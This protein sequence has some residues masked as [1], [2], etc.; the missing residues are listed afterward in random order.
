[1]SLVLDASAALAWI[2]ERAD[3]R[4]R[5]LADRLL[6]TLTEQQALVPVLWHTE[7][8]NAVLVAE[9]RGVIREAQSI[10]YLH[11]LSHLPIV[12]DEVQVSTRQG[13]VMALGREHGLSAYD[14]TYLELALR[15]GSVLASFDRKLVAAT[16]AAGG[17]IF[18]PHD[19]EPA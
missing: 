4:E 13:L 2:F 12:T 17:A 18:G 7:V 1:M 19:P 10:D 9:R 6:D 15:T 5:T 3:A 8:A 14:A 16:R 11:R